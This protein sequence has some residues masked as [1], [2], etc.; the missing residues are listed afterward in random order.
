MADLG[1]IALLL[2]LVLTIYALGAY[3]AGIKTGRAALLNSGRDGVLAAGILTSAA[4]LALFYLLATSDFSVRYVYEYTNRNLPLLYK[5]AAFWAG[6]AGS[7]LLWAWLLAVFTAVVNY[8]GRDGNISLPHVNLIL[9]ANSCFFLLLLN[10]VANPFQTTPV[11]V[12]DGMGLNPLLQDQ[13]MVIHPLTLYLGY[14]GLAVPFALAMAS[15]LTGQAGGAWIRAARR[16][17]LVAWMFLSL[18]NL[19]GAQWAYIELGWGGYWAWDPVENASFIPWLTATA[20]LHSVVLEERQGMLKIWNM[21]LVAVTYLLTIFGTYI[22]RSGVLASVHAF[23]DT[24]LGRMFLAF[25]GVMLIFSLYLILTRLSLLRQGQEVENL[26]SREGS[27]LLNN[28]LLAGAAFAVLWGTVFPLI[29]QLSRGAKLTLS[30]AFF[31]QVSGPILL[32]VLGLMGICPL[33]TRQKPALSRVAAKMILPGLVA[34]V[35]G[36][37]MHFLYPAPK[38]AATFAFCIAFFVLVVILREFLTAAL[39]CSRQGRGGILPLVRMVA[40]D[41]RRW[42]GFIVHLGIVIMAF[43]IIGSN[44]YQVEVIRTVAAGEKIAIGAYE[45]TYNGLSQRTAGD[46]MIIYAELPV[47]HKGQEAGKLAPEKIY[48]AHW[49]QPST[50]VAIRG[51]LQ[52]DLYVILSS[53]EDGGRAATFKVAINPLMSLLWLGGYILVAGTVLAVWPAKTGYEL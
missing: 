53:W 34:L 32:T 11:P 35:L 22:T 31:N 50:E 12:Q 17:M 1:R 2:A 21:A 38:I 33:L 46:R 4:A 39:A 40:R 25:L 15:L 6:N 28:L 18:G 19:F 23:G 37:A 48:Y 44:A 14:V 8:T 20:L 45:L 27:F 43:G 41:R 36:T 30:P 16:W 26:L 24:V 47:A 42:G 5:L 51:S 10:F 9:L 29:S 52:E 3:A 7:L 49:G 13:G